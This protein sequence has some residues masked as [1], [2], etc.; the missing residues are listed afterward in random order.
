MSQVVVLIHAFPVDRTMWEPVATF[1]RDAG[2]TVLMPDLP[3]FG[4]SHAWPVENYSIEALADHIYTIIM[5]QG[6]GQ[7]IVGGC[8][9]GGYILLDLLRRYPQCV[10]GAIF[11][12]THAGADSPE[13][14]AARMTMIEEVKKM[15]IIPLS[16]TMPEKMLSPQASPHLQAQVATAITRQS[17]YGIMGLQYAMAKR[18]DQSSLLPQLTMPILF[19]VGEDDPTTPPAVMR[20]MADQCTK[21]PAAELVV[22]PAARH[23]AVLE[24]PDL[25]G[26]ALVSFAQNI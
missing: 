24:R 19:I 5:Q 11:C 13:T 9:I 20:T 21:A 17:S 14:V 10:Q 22:I 26:P 4:N 7:A 6:D 1:L 15:G 16:K 25:V 8:S 18:S 2:H 12:D 3:G 23:L